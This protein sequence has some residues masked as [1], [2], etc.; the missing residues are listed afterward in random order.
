MR[1][2]GNVRRQRVHGRRRRRAWSSH[3]LLLSTSSLCRHLPATLIAQLSFI[4][5]RSR[6]IRI[7]ALVPVHSSKLRSRVVISSLTSHHSGLDVLDNTRTS[8]IIT[9]IKQGCTDRLTILTLSSRLPSPPMRTNARRDALCC[10]EG[11][12]RRRREV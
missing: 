8:L 9:L 4:T 6:Q 7:H 11:I 1:E 2:G 10:E 3:S 12:G 5:Q